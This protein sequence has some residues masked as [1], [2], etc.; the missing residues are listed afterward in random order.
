ML[1]SDLDGF[2][3]ILKKE[4]YLCNVLYHRA[5]S[6]IIFTLFVTFNLVSSENEQIFHLQNCKNK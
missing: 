3:W 1:Q 4:I 6:L 2:V 5:V